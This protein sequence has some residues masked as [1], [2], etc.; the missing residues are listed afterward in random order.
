VELSLAGGSRAVFEQFLV[1]C[2]DLLNDSPQVLIVSF[3]LG[4]ES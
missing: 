3:R 1:S 2:N 4:V